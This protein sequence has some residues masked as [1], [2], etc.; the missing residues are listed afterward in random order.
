MEK[1][2][3]SSLLVNHS[4]SPIHIL[5]SSIPFN[6][7]APIN[8]SKDNITLT[9]SHFESVEL[10]SDYIEGYLSDRN[11]K[12]AYG[13]YMEERRIYERSSYFGQNKTEQRNIH[14]GIDFWAAEGTAVLA[15]LNSVVHSFKNN[16]NFGDYGPTIILKHTLGNIPF[17]TLYGHLSL[18]SLEKVAVGKK[19]DVGDKIAE[20]GKPNINGEYPPHLHFQII[21]DLQ[22]NKGDYPGVSSLTNIDF[23][24][25]NCPNPDLLLK[26]PTT[27]LQ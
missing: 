18:E 24:R 26:M 2:A 6:L 25:E 15:P 4:K 11:A 17:Y 3:L 8:L 7:Y 21:N 1:Y 13:G 12:V 19:Y 16:N 5:D 23:Y 14:L 22:G 27:F 20:L 9:K 10:F